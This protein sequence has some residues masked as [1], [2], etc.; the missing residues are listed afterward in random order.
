LPLPLPLPLP[1]LEK[2]D[3]WAAKGVERA[4][5]EAPG[6]GRARTEASSSSRKR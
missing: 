2:G 6:D 3:E 1:R 4:V 5:G